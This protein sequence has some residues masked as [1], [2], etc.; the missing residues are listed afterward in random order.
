MRIIFRSN[1]NKRKGKSKVF[2][3]VFLLSDCDV[4]EQPNDSEGEGGGSGDDG[5]V[6]DY[7]HW[8]I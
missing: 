2:Y 1:W 4:D 5:G 7:T 8:I 6:R 3:C